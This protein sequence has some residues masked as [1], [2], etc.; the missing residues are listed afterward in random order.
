MSAVDG[1]TVETLTAVEA[2]T[3]DDL[4]LVIEKGIKT[5]IEVGKALEQIRDQRLYRA[6]F[7]TFEEYLK[8]RWGMSRSYGYRQ[9]EG[10]Q[11][12]AIVSPN[13]DSP[14]PATESVARALAPL[15]DKPEQAR[16]A[17][18]ETVEEHGPAPTASQARKVVE[19]KAKPRPKAKP[20]K[21]ARPSKREVEALAY[22]VLE[23]A[24]ALRR[25]VAKLDEVSEARPDVEVPYF[26]DLVRA[27]WAL[28][29]L[30]ARLAPPADE[31]AEA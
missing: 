16:Q 27:H 3:L 31:D 29:D 23:R 9:I 24:E 26:H 21:P 2:T 4:E 5:F 20:A 17:W 12:A 11:V 8:Q 10:A 6:S 1:I 18:Q 7:P 19:S 25:S 28:G 14:A 15:K 13:G 22:K 30:L